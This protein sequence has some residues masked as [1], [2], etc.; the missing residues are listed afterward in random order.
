MPMRL[1]TVVLLCIASANGLN[2]PSGAALF[3]SFDNDIRVPHSE[4]DVETIE[5]PGARH[6][7]TLLL[8]EQADSLIVGGQ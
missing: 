3:E 5:L 4:S 1:Y 6:L 8:H 2:V 7:R